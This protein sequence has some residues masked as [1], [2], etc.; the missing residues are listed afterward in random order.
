MGYPHA[1][2]P[3]G[4]R[5]TWSHGRC[6]GSAAPAGRPPATAARCSPLPRTKNTRAVSP[7]GAD[8]TAAHTVGGRRRRTPKAV[9]LDLVHGHPQLVRQLLSHRLR[10]RRSL[11]VRSDL[12]RRETA[13]GPGVVLIAQQ[14]RVAAA[15]AA[16]WGKR[17]APRALAAQPYR[18]RPCAL[19][20]ARAAALLSRSQPTPRPVRVRA[21][22]AAAAR[23]G[24]AGGDTH[25]S[26]VTPM[27]FGTTPPPYTSWG[28]PRR[29]AIQA[30]ED[31]D[32]EGCAGLGRT[33]SIDI[34]TMTFCCTRT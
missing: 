18:P 33:L 1:R 24:R 6:R 4:S 10:Q 20:P 5:L 31:H 12:L 28:G 13:V 3:G 30:S 7:S 9:D 19:V 22:G 11:R 27:L 17:G 23:A 2:A 29:A 26:T 25:E 8:F 15:R 14:R 34:F 32:C 21:H 16:A